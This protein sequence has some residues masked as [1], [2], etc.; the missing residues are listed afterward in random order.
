MT[1]HTSGHVF[2]TSYHEQGGN[3]APFSLH[4]PSH[5]SRQIHDVLGCSQISQAFQGFLSFSVSISYA[6]TS[7][8]LSYFH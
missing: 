2:P 8:L 7:F 6:N 5:N 4:Q 3:V 1:N